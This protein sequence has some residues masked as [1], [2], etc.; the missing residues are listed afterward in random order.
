MKITVLMDN[1]SPRELVHEW[2]YS[3]Y[4]EYNHRTYLLDAGS[5]NKVFTNANRLGIDLAGVDD[6]IL[7][8]AH[9]DHSRGFT[10]FFEINQ[11]AL[12]VVSRKVDSNC[13][14]KVGLFNFYVGL[15]KKLMP[16][17]FN[18][19][20][21]VDDVTEL[22]TG[23]YAMRHQKREEQT[24][25]ANLFRQK[26]NGKYIEDCFNHEIN[27]IFDLPQG[28]VVCNSCSH[29]GVVNIIEEVK[30][31][32]P[33]KRISTFIG[34]FHLAFEKPEVVREIGLALEKENLDAIYT[35]HC[36]GEK[37]FVILEKILSPKISETQV[38]ETIEMGEKNE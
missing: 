23:V 27:L 33:N 9:F 21:F 11:K 36:T 29:F 6:A 4:I 2:G 8:H 34:G 38:G 19:Q 13:Y 32:F 26:V 35:G 15:P 37:A 17:T 25:S 20:V 30:K 7:S 22:S 28:L 31:A 16:N 5:S 12:F 18:R 14:S 10:H 1:L 3:L 24:R